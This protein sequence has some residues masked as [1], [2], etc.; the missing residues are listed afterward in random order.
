MQWV[1][2]LS[3]ID[4]S[5]HLAEALCSM[6][7]NKKLHLLSEKPPFVLPAWKTPHNAE[8]TWAALRLDHFTLTA[9]TGSTGSALLWWMFTFPNIEATLARAAAFQTG[10]DSQS[11]SYTQEAILFL[12]WFGNEH[13]KALSGF[14]V[15][16]YRLHN[17]SIW[18]NRQ[19]YNLA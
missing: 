5:L 4:L 6:Q 15:K 12:R 19:S 7:S 8:R 17:K 18:Q 2:S 16:H 9:R 11:C 1:K 14:I 13:I 3:R 10:G